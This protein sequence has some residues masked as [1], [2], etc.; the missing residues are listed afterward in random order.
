MKIINEADDLQAHSQ[1]F[2]QSIGELSALRSQVRQSTSFSALL[3]PSFS[4][5]HQSSNSTTSSASSLLSN[6]S[7][8]A[9]PKT[10]TVPLSA[11]PP[12]SLSSTLP[13]EAAMM[14]SEMRARIQGEQEVDLLIEMIKRNEAEQNIARA[15]Q[16]KDVWN[17]KN[18]KPI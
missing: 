2:S 9:L 15:R 4:T 11:S 17:H 5:N 7:T 13:H 10:T 16:T 18:I 1:E 3:N 8:Q 12:P 6:R 14:S